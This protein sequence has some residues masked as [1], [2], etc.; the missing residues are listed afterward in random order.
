MSGNGR[1]GGFNEAACAQFERDG[2][3]IARGLASAAVVTRLREVALAHLAEPRLPVEYEADT[4][5]PG[6]P[7]SHDAPG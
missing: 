2:Y 4:Q 6:A 5:Y 7:A 1:P 3:V